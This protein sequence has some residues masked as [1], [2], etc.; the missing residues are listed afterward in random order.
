MHNFPIEKS[1]R[2]DSKTAY[3]LV[4]ALITSGFVVV[5]VL[6]VK[7]CHGLNVSLVFDIFDIVYDGFT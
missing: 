4:C 5:P 2:S 6:C 1:E 7:S 3:R